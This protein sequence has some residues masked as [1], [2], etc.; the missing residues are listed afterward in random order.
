MAVFN[1]QFKINQMAKDMG[2]KSKELTDLLTAKGVSD[3]KNQK[4]LTEHE[5]SVLFAT[6]TEA[7]QVDNIY[8]YMDGKEPML[9]G[10]DFPTGGEVI[11]KD[12]IP[13]I[14]RTGR[15]SVKIRGRYKVEDNKIVFYEIPYGVATENLMNEIG[16]AADS[17]KINGIKNLFTVVGF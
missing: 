11:N 17:G 5:F 16:E 8:D 3:V 10:P 9:P 1:P 14:M 12:D 13:T 2:L 6:L 15:G 7:N 4:S